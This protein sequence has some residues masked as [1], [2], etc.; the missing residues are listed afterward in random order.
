M[1]ASQASDVG[2]IPITRSTFPKADYVGLF[3]LAGDGN[4]M[5]FPADL[6]GGK[7][8][9]GRARQGKPRPGG[10][11]RAAESR[12]T[13]GDSRKS[14]TFPKADFV[15]LFYFAFSPRF[16][17]GGGPPPPGIT[18]KTRARRWTVGWGCLRRAVMR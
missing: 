18:E 15:G 16:K 11:R 9:A 8:P 10:A 2:S 14:S 17:E 6:R 1:E 12:A 5:G 3:Y 7:G 13:E 4:R